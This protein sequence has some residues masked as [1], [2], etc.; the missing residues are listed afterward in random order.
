MEKTTHPTVL[1]QC[2]QGLHSVIYN[3]APK[4]S[5][6]RTHLEDDFILCFEDQTK[7]GWNHFWLGRIAKSWGYMNRKLLKEETKS[8][9]KEKT[10]IQDN[11]T[12]TTK[13]A[14]EIINFTLSIW[15]TRNNLEHGDNMQKTSIF[16]R[17]EALEKIELYYKYV[18]PLI[19]SQ[20]EWLFH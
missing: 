12:W 11:I 5:L 3:H 19:L 2:W 20:N 4:S 17:E 1:T 7:I 10:H 9:G 15:Q 16:E 8:E 13:L 6:A 14:R 18:R